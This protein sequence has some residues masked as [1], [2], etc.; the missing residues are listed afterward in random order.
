MTLT[1]RAQAQAE[2]R[3][4]QH[5]PH[6]HGQDEGEIGQRI[7]VDDPRQPMRQNREQTGRHDPQRMD[8]LVGETIPDHAAEA[9]AER[10]DHQPRQHL[11]QPQHHG[12]NGEEQRH[13]QRRQTG[14][15]DGGQQAG[16][17]EHGDDGRDRTHGHDALGAEVHHPG[18]LVDDQPRRRQQEGCGEYRNGGGPVG[19]ETVHARLSPAWAGVAAAGV[20][21]SFAGRTLSR[22]MR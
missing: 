13:R 12:E 4:L 1:H 5:P 14:T 19:E 3:A 21:R 9:N 16:A 20:A 11:L 17:G 18:P 7:L 22:V 10:E 15:E 6:H 2:F 8:G